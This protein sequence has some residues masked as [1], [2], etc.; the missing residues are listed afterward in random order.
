MLGLLL[1]QVLASCLWLGHS[2]VVTSFTRCPQFFY[3][4]TPPNDAL[5]PQNPAWICQQY[6]NSHHY[7]TLYN[8]DNRIP[9]YS[10]YIYQPG[11][12]I[13]S[14]VWFVEPQLIS[15]NYSKDMHTEKSIEDQYNIPLETIG[16]NQAINKDYDNLQGLD[17]GQL[18]PCG[19]QTG[20]NSKWATFTLTNT[21]PLNSTLNSGKWKFYENQTMVNNTQGCDIT[22]VIT[23]A[24]PGSTYTP[25]GRVNIPS[26]IWSAACCLE[27]GNPTRAWGA[28]AKNDEDNV[29]DLSLGE[30][31]NLLT[32]LYGKKMISLF[33]SACPRK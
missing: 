12:G 16:Q 8:K 24:V 6:S 14:P 23:G 2:E 26:H 19:H 21:V 30:L 3:A 1:L 27:G 32:M 9:V 7:A 4:Q 13:N 33:T 5:N 15:Q 22:Y 20:D 11:Q 10:A 28:F 18:T 25:N 31:E 17:P 29:E